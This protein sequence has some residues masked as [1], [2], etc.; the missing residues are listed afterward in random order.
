[1]DTYQFT[2]T[3]FLASY[4]GCDVDKL[5]NIDDLRLILNV[6]VLASGA[7][8][9][10]N[11]DHVFKSNCDPP[12]DGYTSVFILSESHASIHTY[13]ENGACFIDLFTCGNHCSY[14]PFDKH[15][16]DYLHPKSVNYQVIKRDSGV[17]L[18]DSKHSDYT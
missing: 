7:T 2:G 5:T 12:I 1:M 10:G 11:M 14:E 4:C 15:L 16:R 6:S 17:Q 18:I 3:H 8:I 13:P 9:L